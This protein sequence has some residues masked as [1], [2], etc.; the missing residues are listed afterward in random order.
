M[1]RGPLFGVT[2]SHVSLVATYVR[3]SSYCLILLLMICFPLVG[4][5]ANAV[6]KGPHRIGERS[7]VPRIFLKF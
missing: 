6:Q 3:F 5:S 1:A 4:F 7:C 2:M